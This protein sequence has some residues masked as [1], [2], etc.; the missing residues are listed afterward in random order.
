[1]KRT[2][3]SLICIPIAV[4]VLL[5]GVPFLWHATLD[6]VALYRGISLA[7]GTVKQSFRLNYSGSYSMGIEVERKFP[8]A[9]L[10][11][12]VGISGPELLDPGTCKNN[13]AVLRY[14]WSLTCDGRLVQ[15]GSSDKIIGGGYTKD[16]MEAVFGFFDGRRGDRCQLTLRFL[17]DGR[18]LAVAKPKLKVYIELL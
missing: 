7:P 13:P 12:L 6:N 10:Q 1:M 2:T 18:E 8:H 4:I 17:Q 14:T 16:T 15:V 9:V 11:C 5:L 3:K